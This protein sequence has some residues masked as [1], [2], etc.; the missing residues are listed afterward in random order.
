MMTSAGPMIRSGVN[1]ITPH[2]VYLQ[3]AA[4]VS[5]VINLGGNENP[6]G[7]SPPAVEAARQAALEMHRYAEVDHTPLKDEIGR[8]F[9]LDPKKIV[10]GPGSD[11]LLARLAIGYLRPGDEL[12]YS[13]NGYQKIPKYAYIVGA[14]PV[15]AA[16]RDLKPDVDALLRA[17][18]NKTRI[19]MVANPDNPSGRHL[20]AQDVARLHAGLPSDVLLVL[21]SAYA[22][23]A[24]SPD[25]EVPR[26]LIDGNSNVVM[27]RTFSKLFACA[28]GRLGWCYGPS[29]IVEAMS[30]IGPTYP[31]SNVTM[32]A[33]RAALA[34]REHIARSLQHNRT[35]RTWL[36]DEL[37][38]LG[39]FVYPSE[40]N[41]LLVRFDD[42]ERSAREACRHLLGLGIVTARFH[43]PDFENH[44][45]ITIGLEE[46]L[47]ALV[48]GLKEFLTP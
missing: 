13:V 35:W 1:E 41:F 20:G 46:E 2:M 30:R 37:R 24:E 42:P 36:R 9:Q 43:G 40:T 12:V 25:Y 18:T 19:V 34:D 11:E 6:H 48:A 31:L 10:C 33:G 28:G 17:V 26:A 38:S 14:R 4:D 16:D 27:T 39:V 23:Y 15:A 7:P 44:L 21:D 5:R 45:R 22:E 8:Y 47:R 29:P 3:P 32:A